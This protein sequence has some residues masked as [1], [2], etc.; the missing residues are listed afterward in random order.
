MIGARF[1]VRSAVIRMD[2]VSEDIVRIHDSI[3]SEYS[4]AKRLLAEAYPLLKTEPKKALKLIDRAHAEIKEESVVAAEYNRVRERVR[5]SDD[6]R[7]DSIELK[8]HRLLAQGEYKAARKLV[9]KLIE[10]T[11]GLE[12]PIS[13]SAVD[14]D[15]GT[16]RIE[17]SSNRSVVVI[18]IRS[19]SNV[20]F[21]PSSFEI[22][23]FESRI[24]SCTDS[25]GCDL[26]VTVE[27]HD[28]GADRSLSSFITFR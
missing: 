12:H 24:V 25:K 4:E 1:A 23:P 19:D 6:D 15:G 26:D 17:N 27:Y 11:R 20:T 5:F 3:P 10:G 28:A 22:Q 13:L 2:V 18:L 16:I 7:L 21:N 8:Y 9:S 14:S